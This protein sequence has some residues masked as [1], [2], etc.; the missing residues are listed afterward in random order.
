M[1]LA[2]LIMHLY[3]KQNG[4]EEEDTAEESDTGGDASTNKDS[5]DEIIEID[6]D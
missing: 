1:F 4:T 3:Y 2:G 5:G 6:D